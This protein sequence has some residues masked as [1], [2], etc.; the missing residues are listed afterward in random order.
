[1]VV[2]HLRWHPELE[3]FAEH[4]RHLYPRQRRSPYTLEGLAA[5][6]PSATPSAAER[7]G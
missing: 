2:S 3:R 5:C 1:M 7:A 4:S 6:G